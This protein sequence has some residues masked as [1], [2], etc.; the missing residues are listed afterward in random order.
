MADVDPLPRRFNGAAIVD[1]SDPSDGV[2]RG[3]SA[4]LRDARQRGPGPSDSPTAHD[5]NPEA[6]PSQ[7]VGLPK[8]A[9]RVVTIEGQPEVGPADPSI[10]ALPAGRRTRLK[11]HH[12]FRRRR[13]SGV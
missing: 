2:F 10:G 13:A 11:E 6:L 5:L 1:S 3:Y 9:P 12:P 4:Q 8:R 7:R